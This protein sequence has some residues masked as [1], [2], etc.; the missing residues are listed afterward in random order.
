MQTSTNL[1]AL[2]RRTKSIVILALF[3][4]LCASVRGEVIEFK[5]KAEWADAV[6][7]FTTIGFTGFP[8]GTWVFE[9]YAHLGV[10]FVDGFDIIGCCCYE[11]Y[12]I[13]GAG[14]DGNAEIHLIFD[15]PLTHIAADFP[16]NLKIELH[17]D[18]QLMYTSS[19]F[20]SSGDFAFGGL[21]S[22]HP[23]DEARIFDYD[24][25]VN[26]D[27]LHFGPP[28]PVP[29]VFVLLSVGFLTTQRRRR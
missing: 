14:L 1:I 22:S 27:D 18:G 28:I 5:D 8:D 2:A 3:S 11:A 26:L 4:A 19:E 10:H 9:Q 25:Q 24:D 29:S 17:R 15:E 16:G 6:G 12:P 23:F 7:V 13:D 20:G 21:W